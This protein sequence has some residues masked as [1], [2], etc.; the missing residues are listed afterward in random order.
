M[1][2]RWYRG[3]VEE[4]NLSAGTRRG[5]VIAG[6]VAGILLLA[7][8]LL[9]R[10]LQDT[11]VAPAEERTIG[12]CSVTDVRDESWRTKNGSWIAVD[13]SCGGLYATNDTLTDGIRG[14]D[15]CLRITTEA[16]QAAE[17]ILGVRAAEGITCPDVP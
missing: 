7:I 14:T 16:G 2:A 15:V 4:P 3:R 9:P 6:S 1:R 13:T 11:G 12:P 10:I 17:R 8:I 5:L